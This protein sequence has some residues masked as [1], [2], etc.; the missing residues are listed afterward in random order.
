MYITEIYTLL[1]EIYF[2]FVFFGLLF[3][4]I[5]EINWFEQLLIISVVIEV[6]SILF[7]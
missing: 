6:Q 1:Y 5:D 7:S 2:I 4:A 3:S